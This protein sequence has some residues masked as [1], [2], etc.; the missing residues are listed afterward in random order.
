MTEDQFKQLLEQNTAQFLEQMDKRLDARLAERLEENNALLL[1]QVDEKLE[2]NNAVLFGQVS[3]H[4]DTRFD[5]LRMDLTSKTDRIYNLVDGLTKRLE[6]DE[7]ERAAINAEQER[8]NDWIGQ[9]A[10]ATNTKLVPEP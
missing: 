4:F 1:E 8:Q 3:R 9:L 7:Q 5:E 6:T 2:Q 10:N